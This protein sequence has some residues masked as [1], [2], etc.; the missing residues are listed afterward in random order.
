MKNIKE[1]TLNLYT[2]IIVQASIFY[3]AFTVIEASL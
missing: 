2:I 3:T 1:T